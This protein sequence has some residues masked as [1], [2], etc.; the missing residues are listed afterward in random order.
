V[1]AVLLPLMFRWLLNL[2]P[3]PLK[4]EF[5]KKSTCLFTA[6]VISVLRLDSTDVASNAHQSCQC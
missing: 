4:I 1:E 3:F 2:L 5:P 6:V